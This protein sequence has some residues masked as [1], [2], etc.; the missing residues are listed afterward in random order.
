[1]TG[2]LERTFLV[3]M[4]VLIVLLCLM[5]L[6]L[7]WRAVFRYSATVGILLGFP[8]GLAAVA[9]IATVGATRGHAIGSPAVWLIGTVAASLGFAC[10]THVR[11]ATLIAKWLTRTA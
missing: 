3:A 6:T 10:F 8:A 5:L 7:E 4:Y 1:M 11:W 2:P 9:E